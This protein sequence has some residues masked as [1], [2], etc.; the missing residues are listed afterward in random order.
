MISRSGDRGELGDARADRLAIDQHR[1]G[2][3]T[4]FAAA[5]FGTRQAKVVAQH[6]KQRP[7]AFGADAD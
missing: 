1:T 2:P 4:A 6:A 5:V 7:L 3:A